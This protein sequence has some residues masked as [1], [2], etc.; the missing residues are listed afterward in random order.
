MVNRKMRRNVNNFRILQSVLWNCIYLTK[1]YVA[2]SN[3]Y[4]ASDLIVSKQKIFHN[5]GKKID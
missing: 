3:L 1:A 4:Y 5:M 2:S